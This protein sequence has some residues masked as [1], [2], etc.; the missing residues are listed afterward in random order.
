MSIFD[1]IDKR[2]H[3][4]EF[5][6]QNIPKK[7]LIE[8]CL[9]K[10]WKVTPSKQNFMPYTVNVLGPDNHEAKLKILSISQANQKKINEEN[11]PNHT[12]LGNS[13]N[14][15]YLKTAPYILLISQRVCKP[16]PFVQSLIDD[17]NSF[18]EQMHGD[19][20]NLDDIMKTTAFEAGLFVANLWAFALEHNIDLNCNACFPT[21][22]NYWRDFYY[23]QQDVVMMCAM[24]YCKV[25]RRNKNTEERFRQDY[26]PEPHEIIKWID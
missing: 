6:S 17:E 25:P 12:E 16:N 5:D 26:K 10:A 20:K 18:F 14:F 9:W 23:I 8:E 13:P 19:R 24:G 7:S 11:T 21:D 22:K 1:V 15:R 3:I 4:L 2:Q